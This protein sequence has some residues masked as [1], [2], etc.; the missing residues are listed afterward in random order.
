LAERRID[1]ARTTSTTFVPFVRGR[2]SGVLNGLAVAGGVQYHYVR[3]TLDGKQLAG[4][5]GV[6]GGGRPMDPFLSGI[7][8]GA[9][10]GNNGVP[11]GLE[12]EHELLVE[13][14]GSVPS[15]QTVFWAS[16]VIAP[17][18]PQEPEA[19][20]EEVQGVPH[21]FFESRGL[22]VLLGPARWSRVVLT[23]D[24]WLPGEWIAGRVELR[25]DREMEQPPFAE[26][27]PLVLRPSGRTRRL[28]PLMVLHEVRGEAGFEIPPDAL[29]ERRDLRYLLRTGRSVE[30]V[31]ELAGYANYPAMLA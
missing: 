18:A 27:V 12:F 17:M 4:P 8:G 15:P 14:R 13:I 29:D 22:R 28:E 31:A 20:V 6:D 7:Q 24:V 21:R 5:V 9:A 25:A 30:I 2:G 10:H 1:T 3:V 23:S 11:I 19:P 26:T 16:Y